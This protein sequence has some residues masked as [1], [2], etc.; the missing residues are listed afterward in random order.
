MQ[1]FTTPA[2]GRTPGPNIVNREDYK[3]H[4]LLREWKTNEFEILIE[5]WIPETGWESTQILVDDIELERIR[6]A[7]TQPLR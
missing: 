5:R 3:M 7:L 1:K 2:P 4:V 6:N